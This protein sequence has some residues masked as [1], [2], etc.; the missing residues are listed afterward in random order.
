[1][2]RTADL[3]H[4]KTQWAL[5]GTV[6]SYRIPAKPAV[7]GGQPAVELPV[8]WGRAPTAKGKPGKAGSGFV[9]DGLWHA[10]SGLP[11]ALGSSHNLRLGYH[12]LR[13]LADGTKRGCIC[14]S[15]YYRLK[16]GSSK[17]VVVGTTHVC[18]RRSAALASSRNVSG[19]QGC[20]LWRNSTW[21]PSELMNAGAA[22]NGIDF[23]RRICDS[24]ISSEY[25]LI[26]A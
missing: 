17:S 19:R 3:P 11:C 12:Q 9:S 5:A 25:D 16:D 10:Q 20:G 18:Q 6:W 14:I 4:Q 13:L 23:S 1:M 24:T 7:P 8:L 22:W 21:H 2:T 26:E 15:T